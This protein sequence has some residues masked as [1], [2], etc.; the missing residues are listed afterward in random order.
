MI[1]FKSILAD[2]MNSFLSLYEQ[3]V[4]K[5]S[6][7]IATRHLIKFDEYLNGI[8]CS[9]KNLTEKQIYDWLG[10]FDIKKSSVCKIITV[11]RGF[12]RHLEGYGY[13]PFIPPYPKVR[14]D[15]VAYIFTDE[16]LDRIFT[17]AD[18]GAGASKVYPYRA[19]ELPII[20]RILYGCGMRL[21]EV[22]NLK[23]EN[24]DFEH[25]SFVL[26]K[27]KSKEYRYVPMKPSLLKIMKAY[28]AKMGLVG[29]RDRY[30]FPGKDLDTPIPTAS[31][32]EP[33]KRILNAA[34]ISLE[35]Y[36]RH[37]RGPCL[38]CFRHVFAH[39]SFDAGVSEGWAEEDQV[40]WL[41]VYLGHYDMMATEKYLKYGGQ[42]SAKYMER[43][44]DYSMDI[45]P[46]VNFDE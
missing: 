17:I 2:E 14:D 28:C 31:L 6:Y 19:A 15:Y 27:T 44:D 12:L 34:G 46:E 30:L 13:R 43:F 39:K 32:R 16:E 26:E 29:V 18:R 4:G 37:E 3:E 11:L 40:P 33:F 36:K 9:D 22:L 24:L 5:E 25:G 8:S 23:T 42:E 1:E 10:T 20:L 38:Y 35:G 21:G 7:Y 41:S 45:L